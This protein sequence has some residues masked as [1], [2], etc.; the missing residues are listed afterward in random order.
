MGNKKVW[1]GITIYLENPL[2]TDDSQYG[3][4]FFKSDIMTHLF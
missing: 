1:C 3:G 4:N 2:V